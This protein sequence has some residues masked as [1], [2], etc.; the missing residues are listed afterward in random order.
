MNMITR[1]FDIKEEGVS[2]LSVFLSKAKSIKIHDQNKSTVAT[3]I[4][5]EMNGEEVFYLEKGNYTILVDGEIDDVTLKQVKEEVKPELAHLILM[6]DAKDF[7]VVDGVPEIPADGLSFTK[8]VV[9]KEDAKGNSL[10]RKKDN[11]VVYLRT[12][13]GAI[14]DADGLDEIRNLTLEKGKGEFRLYS[15]NRKRVATVKVISA[16]RVIQDTMIIIEFF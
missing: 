8:I 13:A 14:K 7:H 2:K 12:D 10:T 5:N 4:G 6:S 16:N 1:E 15:E 3:A 9:Q 11:D